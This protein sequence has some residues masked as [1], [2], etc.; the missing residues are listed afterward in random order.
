MRV[1][2]VHM[3]KTCKCIKESRYKHTWM[4]IKENF[5]IWYISKRLRCGEEEAGR[6]VF[7]HL[8]HIAGGV[9]AHAP[10]GEREESENKDTKKH[11]RRGYKS[12]VL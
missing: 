4:N 9:C 12:K 8:S 3:N 7:A 10:W 11:K 5:S 6:A 1:F 2:R